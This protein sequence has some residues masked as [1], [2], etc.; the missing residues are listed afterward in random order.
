MRHLFLVGTGLVAFAFGMTAAYLVFT[1]PTIPNGNDGDKAG[2]R[3]RQ[4]LNAQRAAMGQAFNRG[5]AAAWT[6]FY[7]PDAEE[8]I[9]TGDVFQG[10]AQ[11]QQHYAKLFGDNPGISTTA[12]VTTERFLT[13]QVFVEDGWWRLV[14]RMD[15][16]AIDGRY[17]NI[18]T[19]RDGQWLIASARTWAPVKAP[20]K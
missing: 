8:I 18:W 5:D 3:N 13:P 4:L 2:A 9:E 16:G 20:K 10:A 11:I 14:D 12:G 15:G 6:K 1:K 7:A 17:T 19:D